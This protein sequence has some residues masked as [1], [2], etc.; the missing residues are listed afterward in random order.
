MAWNDITVEQYQALYPYVKDETLTDIERDCRII[1]ILHNMTEAQVDRLPFDRFKKLRASIQFL[2]K[3]EITS[4]PVN[5]LRTP[6]GKAYRVNY[7]VRKVPIARYA[8]V[9]FFAGN[10]KEIVRNLHCILAS[11]VQPAKRRFGRYFALPYEADQHEQYAHDMLRVPFKHAWY[12]MVFFCNLYANWMRASQAYLANQ[13]P[14]EAEKQ[15]TIN[16]LAGLCNDLDGFIKSNGLPIIT[17]S[18]STKPGK[19]PRLK[20]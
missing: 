5:V 8:E 17:G 12:A 19:W 14:N 20:P 7:D 4:E 9:K 1:G 13:T 15:K 11:M 3:E 2:H 18:P 16:L 6:D 10:E